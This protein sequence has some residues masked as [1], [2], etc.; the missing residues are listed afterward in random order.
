LGLVQLI[1]A[2]RTD[3]LN[4]IGFS[5][6]CKTPRYPP[7]L[8]AAAAM[9]LLHIFCHLQRQRACSRWHIVL[10]THGH[11]NPAL[12]LMLVASASFPASA[13]ATGW[14]RARSRRHLVHIINGCC[15][16]GLMLMLAVVVAA[17]AAAAA[18]FF[19]QLRPDGTVHAAGGTSVTSST[20]IANPLPYWLTLG[21]YKNRPKAETTAYTQIPLLLRELT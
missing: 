14:Y 12:M 10:V 7:Q 13:V 21:A 4:G 17:A 2:G 6:S 18:A 3:Q 15:N 5:S 9:Q 8:L 16:P 19:P 11:C 20:G 1:G